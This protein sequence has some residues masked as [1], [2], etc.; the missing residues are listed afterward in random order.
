[1]SYY[2]Y[3]KGC[4]LPS[5]VKDGMIKT[6]NNGCEKKEKPAAWL[7]KSPEWEIA[8]NIGKVLNGDELVS[9]QLYFSDE[10]DLVAVNVDYMKKKIG[11]CRILISESLPTTSWAKFKYVSKISEEIYNAVDEYTRSIGCPVDKWLC[12]FSPIPKKYWEG[13]EMYVDNEWV[14]WDGKTPIEKFIEIC[15]SCNNN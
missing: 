1:M 4:H 15:L 14:R 12:S 7:S 6:T 13:I 9:G 8:C 11:M 10:I 3:T 5:I 2:H